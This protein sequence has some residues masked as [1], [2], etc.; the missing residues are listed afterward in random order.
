MESI[1]LNVVL[2]T[3]RILPP[4]TNMMPHAPLRTSY[5]GVRCTPRRMGTPRQA[6]VQRGRGE[7][8]FSLCSFVIGSYTAARLTALAS[9]SKKR[10]SMIR[11]FVCVHLKPS[12]YDGSFSFPPLPPSLRRC[13]LST[14][15]G[16]TP[17]A[18]QRAPHQRHASGTPTHQRRT[19]GT[20]PTIVTPAL[21]TKAAHQRHTSGT[22]TSGTAISGI[23]LWQC[24]C[25]LLHEHISQWYLRRQ[26]RM[27]YPPFDGT[28]ERGSSE[29]HTRFGTHW[30][31]FTKPGLAL[32]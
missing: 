28:C 20:T 8:R 13:N 21:G 3:A 30:K 16:G 19:S 32:G 27:V 24:M 25:P 31:P 4:G 15:T 1:Q 6:W 12:R 5:G 18:H 22:P 17:A 26:P 9:H 14:H 29:Y 10:E 23:P 7:C 11:M 2:H